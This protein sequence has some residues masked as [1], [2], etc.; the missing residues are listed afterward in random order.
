MRQEK[1]EESN[2]MARPGQDLIMAGLAGLAGTREIA[3]LHKEKLDRRFSP[4]F[5][6]EQLSGQEEEEKACGQVICGG[7]ARPV[8]LRGGAAD[9][10]PGPQ[11]G[12]PKKMHRGSQA[13]GG[14]SVH[15]PQIVAGLDGQSFDA[16]L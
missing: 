5:L 11:R 7:A 3:C 15:V 1:Q 10:V 9:R 4:V 12:R 16:F 13:G 2:F 6:E 14:R 8:R